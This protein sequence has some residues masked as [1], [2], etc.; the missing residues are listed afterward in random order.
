MSHGHGH[1]GQE[2]SLGFGKYILVLLYIL[3]GG[4]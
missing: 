1:R 2:P 3:L 4:D